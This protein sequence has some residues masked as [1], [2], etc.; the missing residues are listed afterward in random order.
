ML[1]TR[2]AMEEW[3]VT[4][5]AQVQS[6]LLG[7]Q[8]QMVTLRPCY[9]SKCHCRNQ[10]QIKSTKKKASVL[11]LVAGVSPQLLHRLKQENL[12]LKSEFKASLSNL[13]KA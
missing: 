7:T 3:Q 13:T 1:V 5:Q 12:K 2:C 11:G 8:C 10:S 6:E 4:G 9:R